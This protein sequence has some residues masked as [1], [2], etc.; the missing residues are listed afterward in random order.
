MKSPHHLFLAAQ[1]SIS[2][3]KK[4][5]DARVREIIAALNEDK[6]YKKELAYALSKFMSSY[7]RTILNAFFLGE[8]PLQ[9]MHE[10]TGVPLDAVTAYK[11]YLFDDAVFRDKLDRI[12]WVEEQVSYQSAEEVSVLKTA[13]AV[14]TKY[15]AWTLTGEGNFTPAE[16][17]RNVMN[18]AMFRSLA[19][20]VAPL[21]SEIAKEAHNWA[22]TAERAAKTVHLVDPKD[23]EEARKA[24]YIALKHEDTTFNENTMDVSPDQILH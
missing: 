7:Q 14:G 18:D 2:S 16:V 19:H 9:T 6:G 3:G 13:M 12:S 23:E 10:V 21:N 8:A 20:R 1:E 5:K 11:N 17:L 4:S 15:L 24:L 22:K